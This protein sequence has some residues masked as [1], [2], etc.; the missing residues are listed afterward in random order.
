[1]AEK[2]KLVQ[3]DSRPQLV[4]SLT[5]DTTGASIDVSTAT[6]RLR[7]RKANTTTILA[8]LVGT[9]IPGKVQEDGSID[10]TGP[11]AISGAG[12]RC[13]IDWTQDA[14]NQDAG[15]YE[16]E[17]EITFADTTIQTVYDILKFKL[18]SQFA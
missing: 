8:T 3:G 12:G 1:M 16:G 4:L 2:I 13:V 11:Y 17:I 5:D 18:R 6:V 14:L 9:P 7:F 10:F 15:D